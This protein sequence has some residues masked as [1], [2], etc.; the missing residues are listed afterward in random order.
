MSGLVREM[1]HEGFARLRQHFAQVAQTT[2]PVA[3]M[4]LMGRAYRD[5]ALTN[6]HLYMVMFGGATL[7]GFELSETTANTADTT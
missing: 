4:A 7:A 3:D 5:N 2:D 1:I 6:P